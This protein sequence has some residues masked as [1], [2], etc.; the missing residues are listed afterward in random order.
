MTL[1]ACWLLLP[2]VLSLLA[3]G[4]GVLLEKAAG[5]QLPGVLLVP[6]GVAVTIAVAGFTTALDATAELTVPL[7]CV[8]GAAGLLSLA[9]GRAGSVDG[10]ALGV[11]AGV[12]VAFALPVVAS[13]H[14]TF[15]GYVKLDDTAS[16]LAIGDHVLEHGRDTGGL[17]PSSYEATVSSYL[18]NGYPVGS[19]VPVALAH[20]LIGQDAAWLFQPVMAFYAALLALCLYWIAAGVVRSPRARALVV[21]VAAQPALLFGYSLWGGLKEVMLAFLLALFA[22]LVARAAATPGPLR[23][24]LPAAVTIA[25]V[26][27]AA[28]AGGALWLFAPALVALAVA[29]RGVGRAGPWHARAACSPSPACWLCRRSCSRRA[30]SPRAACTC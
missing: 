6:A 13:G 22:G 18:G 30:S 8:L 19:F 3:L 20:K 15:A 5:A 25:A 2:A 21:F 14:A 12:Y 23:G 29:A 16:W 1:A 17:A 24:L 4:C 7:V 28:S 26:L 10:W 27:T 9:R 11:A